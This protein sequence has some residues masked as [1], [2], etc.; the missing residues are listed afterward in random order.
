M[1]F[2]IVYLVLKVRKGYVQSLLGY[3]TK[4]SPRKIVFID[5]ALSLCSFRGITVKI[6]TETTHIPV[7]LSKLFKV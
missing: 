1:S 5:S 4:E 2:E 3:G 6:T 7:L